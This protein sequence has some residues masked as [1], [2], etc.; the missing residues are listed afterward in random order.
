MLT[1]AIL[2]PS[3]TLPACKD[4]VRQ[5]HS[6]NQQSGSKATLHGTSSNFSRDIAAF[7]VQ[8]AT[9]VCE[10]FFMMWRNEFFQPCLFYRIPRPRRWSNLLQTPELRSLLG[11]P[12][13]SLQAPTP[14]SR[15][16]QAALRAG[17]SVHGNSR[18]HLT[19]CN[20]QK[21]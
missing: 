6:P 2:K 8:A 4:S 3:T 10:Y 18:Q 21:L 12:G 5:S 14:S 9:S 7:P 17:Q 19:S 16:T 15:G 13:P 20:R 1:F 11:T